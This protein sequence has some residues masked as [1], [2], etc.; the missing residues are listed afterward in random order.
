MGLCD[1][2]RQSML[3]LPKGKRMVSRQEQLTSSSNKVKKN[4]YPKAYKHAF[5]SFLIPLFI[6]DYLVLFLIQLQGKKLDVDL[7]LDQDTLFF[8]NLHKG[9]PHHDKPEELLSC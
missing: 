2:Q 4:S 7:S 9:K 6:H 3:I 1:F 8:G 5:N